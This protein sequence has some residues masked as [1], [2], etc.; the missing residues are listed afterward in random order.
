MNTTFGR[1]NRSFWNGVSASFT[2]QMYN[3]VVLGTPQTW[4]KVAFHRCA[5]S[6]GITDVEANVAAKGD[7]D[8]LILPT[9]E[10]NLSAAG[11]PLPGSKLIDA[12]SNNY[13]TAAVPSSLSPGRDERGVPRILGGRIDIGACEYDW[14]KD[15]AEDIGKKIVVDDASQN[16]VETEDSTVLLGDGDSLTLGWRAGAKVSEREFLFNVDT[17]TLTITRNGETAATMTSG[18]SWRYTSPDPS[19]V[20]VFSFAGEGSAEVLK[21]QGDGLLLLFK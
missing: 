20:L 14:R 3:C 2:M 21:S 1:E 15:F 17:G 10:I 18:G 5:F 13:Y 6:S 12:G 11:V 7:A 19:D 8:C 4:N 9:S 16:V